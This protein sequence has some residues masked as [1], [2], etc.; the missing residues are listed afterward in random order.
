[1]AGAGDNTR[2]KSRGSG[3]ADNFKRAVGVCM[4]AIS[5]D[6]ELEVAFAKDKPALA[7][8]RARLPDLPKKPSRSDIAITRGLG[9]SMALKRACHDLRIHSR[10]APRASRRA[11]S[12]TPSS[13]RASR[14]SAHAP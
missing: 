4:R 12:T 7:G 10:L 9:D 2:G 6:H 11:P 3:E 14:R 8:S 5:G 13:R 1:M